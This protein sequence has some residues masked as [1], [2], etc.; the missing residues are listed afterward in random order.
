MTTADIPVIHPAG[1]LLRAP[2]GAEF[3]VEDYVPAA[4]AED[5]VAFY[6]GSNN[7]GSYNVDYPAEGLKLVRTAAGM[8]ARTLPSTADLAAAIGRGLG[9]IGQSI[10][11]ELYEA[12][13]SEGDGTVEFLGRTHDGLGIVFTVQVTSVMLSND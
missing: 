13:Y 7:G 1:T 2:D 6:C 10:N 11:L 8:S 4:V 3:V 12:D 5:G 9:S